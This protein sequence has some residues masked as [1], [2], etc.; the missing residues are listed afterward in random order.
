[1]VKKVLN[2]ITIVLFAFA[3]TI[4]SKAQAPALYDVNRMSFNTN[5]FNEM[6]PVIGKDGSIMFCSDRRISA[7]T[8]RTSFD[9]RRLFNIFQ[10]AAESEIGRASCR[11]RE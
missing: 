2:I 8:N 10:V 4:Y 5:Y 6:S 11:E 3:A 7:I 9:G 1:M